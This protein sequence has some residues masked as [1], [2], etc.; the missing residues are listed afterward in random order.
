[1]IALLG[2]GSGAVLSAS[3]RTIIN[4]MLF[5]TGGPE[6]K[7]FFFNQVEFLVYPDDDADGYDVRVDCDDGDPSIHPGMSDA[8]CD[9]VDDDCD[10]AA[11]DEFVSV[12]T[13]CG[14]GACGATGS[15]SCVAGAVV[16]SCTPGTPDR[17]SV[18]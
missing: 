3:R 9:G 4:G 13:T 1:S 12:A 15:T 11:D 6:L 8:T 14:V 7:R 17:K 16:D 18:V 5:D 10:G 2:T